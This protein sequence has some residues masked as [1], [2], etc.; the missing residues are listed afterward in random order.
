MLKGKFIIGVA[1]VLVAWFGLVWRTLGQLEHNVVPRMATPTTTST[2][3]SNDLPLKFILFQGD[4]RGQGVGNHMNGLLAAHLLGDEF[5]RV[6]CVSPAF[7][8][9]TLAFD[10]IHPLAT[11]HCP[12]V[13][14]TATTQSLKKG[15]R[16][17]YSLPP[18]HLLLEFANYYSAAHNKNL[19]ECDLKQKLASDT[20]VWFLRTNMYPQWPD[21]TFI[22]NNY[23]D[24]FYQPKQI[25]QALLPSPPPS[26][27]VHLRKEDGPSDQRGGLDNATLQALGEYFITA[28]EHQ[29]PFLVTNHVAFYIFFEH[30]QW[31]H[32]PWET[33]VHS[34][35]L[36]GN[37]F[38]GQTLSHREQQKLQLWADWYTC[39]KADTV[40]HTFSDFSASAIH[41]QDPTSQS[42]RI[43]RGYNTT[44]QRLE[45]AVEWWRQ[46][47]KERALPLVQRTKLHNCEAQPPARQ[48]NISFNG[49]TLSNS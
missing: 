27:V 47:R 33:V 30:L 6:V 34:A 49:K 24:R 5:Q 37:A 43:I 22:P 32:P 11:Q 45:L 14:E 26:V 40:Y 36:N 20:P 31:R 29:R 3:T 13:I 7:A 38:I 19:N 41:W 46:E 23:F 2:I 18:K 35:L 9:F 16:R 42:S 28:M 12:Q 17:S 15:R 48:L 4:L 44:T 39:L 10:P 25:L 21:A 1:T 8:E